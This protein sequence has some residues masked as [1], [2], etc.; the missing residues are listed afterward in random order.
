MDHLPDNQFTRRADDRLSRGY[1]PP[2]KPV[3]P[4]VLLG[5]LCWGLIVSLLTLLG[6]PFVQFIVDHLHHAGRVS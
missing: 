5:V 3:W 1:T 4:T 2:A 6:L